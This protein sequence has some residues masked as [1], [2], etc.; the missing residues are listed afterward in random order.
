MPYQPLRG[1]QIT[2]DAADVRI[3]TLHEVVA[4]PDLLDVA[5]SVDESWED[6]GEGRDTHCKDCEGGDVTCLLRRGANH[7]DRH[8]HHE[9]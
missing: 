8:G 5:M 3:L 9:D 4:Q 1:H 7:Q 2:P 6:E